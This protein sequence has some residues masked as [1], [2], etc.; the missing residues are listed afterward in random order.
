MA[1]EHAMALAVIVAI[2]F[3][4]PAGALSQFTMDDDAGT[5]ALPH[6]ATPGQATVDEE[7]EEPGAP[8]WAIVPEDPTVGHV[9]V[10]KQ[11]GLPDGLPALRG[12]PARERH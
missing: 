4:A 2:A 5:L 3:F 11:A 10:V 7:I 6:T 12:T 8:P 9:A 1:R